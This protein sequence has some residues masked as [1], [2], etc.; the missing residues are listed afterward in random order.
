MKKNFLPYPIALSALPFTLLSCAPIDPVPMPDPFNPFGSTTTSTVVG[1][2]A[3][4]GSVVVNGT[5]YNTDKAVITVDGVNA[6]LTN[7]APGMKVTLKSSDN[8]SVHE[9]TSIEYDSEVEGTV[10]N[11]YTPT[12]PDSGTIDIMGQTVTVTPETVFDSNV[13]GVT[14]IDQVTSGM[15]CEVSGF[16]SPD[17]TIT[18]T[19]IEVEAATETEYLAMHPEGM[20]LSGLITNLDTVNKTFTIGGQVIDY[21]GWT[22][23]DPSILINDTYVEIST[24]GG[25]DPT[26]GIVITD[27][28]EI[29]GDGI[30]GYKG[31]EGEQMHVK[32]S[33]TTP[34]AG[35]LFSVNGQEIRLTTATEYVGI[36]KNEL[37][38]GIFI[39][40]KGTF[41]VA[42]VLVADSVYG[43]QLADNYG[44]G[45][46]DSIN[47]TDA[48]SGTLT[49]G[50]S[51]YVVNYDTIMI[52]NPTEGSFAPD[53]MF[54]LDSLVV[55]NYVGFKYY[56]DS[57][58]GDMIITHLAR[59]D[60]ILPTF[61]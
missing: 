42:G 16:Q 24:I 45:A 54:N 11:N 59:L 8:G 39:V 15:V 28:V 5:K 50:G 40:V 9:A 1:P 34:V 19:F 22:N 41:D 33:I 7:L 43:M 25:I 4:F 57:V 53:P 23:P 2:I 32:G 12:G 21:S 13:P 10:G 29:E 27:T 18:A 3:S 14:S 58:T 35:D 52:D 61:P 6:T 38:P 56:T 46:I 26:T 55:G 51:P 30:L 17:G 49:V 31:T 44:G 36:S 47:A 48:N 37:M 60:I 20:E